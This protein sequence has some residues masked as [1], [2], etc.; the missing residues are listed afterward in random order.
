MS[1]G[2]GL[3]A[4]VDGFARGYGIRADMDDRAA[5]RED[6]ERRRAIE[7]ER[8]QW[9]RE[10]RA[11]TTK[12]R[13]RTEASRDRMEAI[14]DDA[15]T[16]FEAGKAS[17]AY[18]D[19]DFDEFWTGYALP[20]MQQEALLSGDTAGAAQLAAWGETE[21]ARKGAKLFAGALIKAQS[22]DAGGALDDALEAARV[23]GYMDHGYEI[24]GKVEIKDSAGTIVGYRVTLEDEAG[25]QIEQ[26]VA[27][28]DIAE[29]IAAF[30]NPVAA[31]QSQQAARAKQGER[32]AALEDHEAKARIDA[33][34][35]TAGRP[36]RADAIKTL[37]ARFED[38]L[39]G[40]PSF[41]ELDAAE[42]EALIEEELD[43]LTG[44]GTPP[45][46]SASVVVDDRLGRKV[47]G[48]GDVPV[49]APGSKAPGIVPTPATAGPLI[50]KGATAADM[51]RLSGYREIREMGP[52]EPPKSPAQLVK[53]AADMMVEGTEPSEIARMLIESGVNEVNWPMGLKNALNPGGT[54]HGAGG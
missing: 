36:T 34:Y 42:K 1:I 50:S 19:T 52:R 31:W 29:T 39:D 47:T 15:R 51:E 6:R 18:K 37:R 21:A 43:L 8:L 27:L 10:D 2:I 54:A 32:R 9:E 17:G 5:A 16:T 53:K 45:P 25:N 30:A 41:D 46:P 20:K 28:D 3:G 4:F 48:I 26:D 33:K 44:E 11:Y 22:G 14:A 7:D 40:G 23:Q 35:S 24:A 13:A 12:E 38:S 49:A